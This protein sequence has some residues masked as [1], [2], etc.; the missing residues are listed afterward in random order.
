[1]NGA[2]R[3]IPQSMGH[4]PD[5]VHPVEQVPAAYGPGT[6]GQKCPGEDTPARYNKQ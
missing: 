5:A 1:M 6:K 4:L 3:L 2:Q